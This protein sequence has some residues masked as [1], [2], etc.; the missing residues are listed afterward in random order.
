MPNNAE[1][2]MKEVI[3]ERK[4]EPEKFIDKSDFDELINE[5]VQIEKRHKYQLDK[6]SPRNRKI[7]LRE[8]LDKY[9]SK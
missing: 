8:E 3:N 7:D 4:T 6:S 9:F 5:L 2:L 1:E